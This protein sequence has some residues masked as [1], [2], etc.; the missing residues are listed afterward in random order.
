MAP[1]SWPHKEY[2]LYSCLD[3]PTQSMFT[4]DEFPF[5]MTMCE[6]YTEI[7]SQASLK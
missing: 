4:F 1:R 7:P 6:Y 5:L 2:I 3:F